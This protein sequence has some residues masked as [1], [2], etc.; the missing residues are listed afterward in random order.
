MSDG[1]A[2]RA[3]DEPPRLRLGEAAGFGVAAGSRVGGS[4]RGNGVESGTVAATPCVEV[5]A[6]DPPTVTTSIGVPD[7]PARAPAP[8]PVEGRLNI[9]QPVVTNSAAAASTLSHRRPGARTA[10]VRLGQPE[11]S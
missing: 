6:G 11:M 5:V 3:A 2:A 1:R 7:A 8:E 10:R 4:I 9:E